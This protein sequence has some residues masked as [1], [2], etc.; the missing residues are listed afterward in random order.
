M[1][2]KRSCKTTKNG[3]KIVSKSIPDDSYFTITTE[4]LDP[5]EEEEERSFTKS[6][7]MQES[8]SFLNFERTST[9]VARAGKRQQ[10]YEQI[11][12]GLIKNDVMALRVG[13][14]YFVT[15]NTRDL[16]LKDVTIVR[17]N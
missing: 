13:V 6:R 2:L 16:L 3:K 15:K 11:G 8:T 4:Q 14:K 1:I 9:T 17:G 10:T 12:N 7:S 5:E